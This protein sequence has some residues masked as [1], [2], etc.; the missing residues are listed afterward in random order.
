VVDSETGTNE[1]IETGIFSYVDDILVATTYERK[2]E[3]QDYH[4]NLLDDLTAKA[5]TAGYSFSK[6]KGE[7]IPICTKREQ[8]LLPNLEG[9]P[10]N[11]EETI[12]WLG[13][14]ISEDWK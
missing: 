7:Y 5:G 4:Q 10:L 13:F 8:R 9:T 2:Q 3:G 1:T 14:I 11:R 6:S 12:R